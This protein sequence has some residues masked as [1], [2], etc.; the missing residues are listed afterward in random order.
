MEGSLTNDKKYEI[1]NI[2]SE[3]AK[4]SFV[5]IRKLSQVTGKIVAAFPETLYGPLYYRNLETNKISGLKNSK[6]NCESYVKVSHQSKSKRNWWIQNMQFSVKPIVPADVTQ[7]IYS[8]VSD[9]G[10]DAWE[11]ER[12]TGGKWCQLERIYHIKLKKMITVD[13]RF[14]CFARKSQVIRLY[15]DK[16]CVVSVLK[17]LCNNEL[18]E[19]RKNI[20]EWCIQRDIWFIP[21]YVKSSQNKAD[22]RSRKIYTQG[23]WKLNSDILQKA[24]KQLKFS[25][26]TDL[27]ASRLNRFPKYVA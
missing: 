18:N 24:L 12:Y 23:E 1:V 14:K 8:D 2:A 13:F 15:I 17:I 26:D 16:I 27:F 20:W 21:T 7:V 3:I 25:P 11:N 5:K 19:K 4:K 22:Q 9:I 10:W 6:G